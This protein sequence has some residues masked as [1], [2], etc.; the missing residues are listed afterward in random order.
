MVAPIWARSDDANQ[1]PLYLFDVGG[2]QLEM[3][4]VR[5]AGVDL[6]EFVDREAQRELWAAM[7]SGL[8]R[9][10]LI[11][12]TVDKVDLPFE[13]THI[14]HLPNRDWLVMDDVSNIMTRPPDI[15]L[16]DPERRAIVRRV[17]L[18]PEGS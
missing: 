1:L 17:E 8:K 13:P 10:D 11:T 5:N 7:P 14:N 15:V 6:L 2:P 4:E 9:V 16:F 18:A 12:G 3:R